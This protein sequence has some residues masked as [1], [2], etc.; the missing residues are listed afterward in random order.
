M[1]FPRVVQSQLLQTLD[2]QRM[3]E[4]LPLLTTDSSSVC[5]HLLCSVLRTQL[6]ARDILDIPT[7]FHY[8][9]FDNHLKEAKVME[10]EMLDVTGSLANSN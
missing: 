8:L 10:R 4:P 5:D 6:L 9:G 2:P 7:Y 3:L 1:G